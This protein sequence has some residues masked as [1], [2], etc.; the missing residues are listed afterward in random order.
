MK[1][2]LI[3]LPA[4]ILFFDGPKGPVAGWGN[5]WW[6]FLWW[7]SLNSWCKE[8]SNTWSCSLLE[9]GGWDFLSPV[10]EWHNPTNLKVVAPCVKKCKVVNAG[11]EGLEILVS[12][13]MWVVETLR[14]DRKSR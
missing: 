5:G 2:Y 10:V 1:N 9:G 13:K 4:I 14:F 3:Y 11:F 7:T 8:C 12:G 6:V